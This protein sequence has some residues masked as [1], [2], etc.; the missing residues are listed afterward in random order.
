MKKILILL[1]LAMLLSACGAAPVAPPEGQVYVVQTGTTLYQIQQTLNGALGTYILTNAAG[2][3]VF[4]WNM[5]KDT[6]GFTLLSNTP[7]S[8]D[9]WLRATGGK[10]NMVSLKDAKDL[11]QYLKQYGWTAITVKDIPAYILASIKEGF[12]YA[13]RSASGPTAIF[14][15]PANLDWYKVIPD[16]EVIQ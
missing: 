13:F 15:I 3:Y 9:A 14:V 12:K 5:G 8:V 1:V 10:A 11:V 2:D 4:I 16:G 6:F 7:Q